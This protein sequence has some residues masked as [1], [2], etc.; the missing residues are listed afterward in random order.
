V[1]RLVGIRTLVTGGTSGIGTAIVERLRSEGAAVVL[2]GRSQERGRAVSD[3]TGASF[4]PADATDADAVRR[5]V[6]EAVEL[7]GGLDGVVL[8]AG[9][10]H[11]GPLA[12]TTD[13]VWDS[14]MEVNLF[15]SYR[16]ALA[17]LPHLRAAG[18]GSIVAISSDAG[19]WVET[20]VGAYSVS[21]RALIVLAQMLGTEAGKDGIRVNVVAPGDTAPGMATFVSGRVERDPSGWLLPPAGRI[22]TAPDAAAAVAF[23]LS[24]DS[25][26][27]NGSVLLVDGGMR[28]DLHATAVLNG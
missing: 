27:C 6:Q 13:E 8:N 16:Y 24:P 7:L 21:K 22:G 26:F 1:S 2:T 15:G 5:S 12:E 3:R 14:I 28:A 4:V 18:G 19:V 20:A 11:E 23:F 25:S 17:C 9:V 10:L